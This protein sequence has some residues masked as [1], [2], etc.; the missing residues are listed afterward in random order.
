M[1]SSRL[2]ASLSMTQD[3]G[4]GPAVKRAASATHGSAAAEALAA[5]AAAAAAAAGTASGA[6][7]DH[8]PSAGRSGDGAGGGG[9]SGGGGSFL[10]VRREKNRLA[11]KRCRD[12]KQAHMVALEAELLKQ[13][14]ANDSLSRHAVTLVGL[15]QQVRQRQA[16]W[17]ACRLSYGQAFTRGKRYRGW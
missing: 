14:K 1:K 10:D 7:T 15:Y 9:G 17:R 12:R 11:A 4:R 5:A 6:D 2:I 3:D 8:S 13:Q 16:G